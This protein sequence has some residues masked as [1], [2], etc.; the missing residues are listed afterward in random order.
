MQGQDITNIRDLYTLPS[1]SSVTIQGVI[2][3]PDYGFNHGQF[4]VQDST[5]GVNV[6]YQNIGGEQGAIVNYDEGDTLKISGKIGTFASLL[7]IEPTLG[8]GIEIIGAGDQIPDPITISGDDISVDSRYLG[9][10]VEI[11]GV[12]LIDA[13]Q[14]PA[15]P[16]T[17]GSGLSV[18]ALV[19]E[20]SLE[21]RIDRG[22]SFFDGSSIPEEPFTIRGILGRFNNN[23]QILP[24]LESDIFQQTTTN[25]F[26]ALKLNNTLKIYPNPVQEEITIEVL[27]RAGTVN[28]VTLYDIMGR[29]MAQWNSLNAKNTNLTLLVPP[30]LNKGNYY[31]S[32]LTENGIRTSK[33]V[34]LN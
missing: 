4:Y 21:I 13:I 24:F 32:I 1:N 29:T 28:Q 22:Q 17:S 25:T 2:N 16:I 8:I 12:T 15:G 11:A 19:G 18:E 27:P 10:R 9:M 7:Q 34:V 31:I 5:G 26:E 14:W 33:T 30:G 3:C 23:V 6:F 20:D